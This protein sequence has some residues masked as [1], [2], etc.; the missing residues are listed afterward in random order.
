MDE[1]CLREYFLKLFLFYSRE[2]NCVK[3]M[4]MAPL[5]KILLV[6]W[7][8]VGGGANNG[9]GLSRV[10]V[11]VW[12]A[13]L[14]WFQDKRGLDPSGL[15]TPKLATGVALSLCPILLSHIRWLCSSKMTQSK[16]SSNPLLPFSLCKSSTEQKLKWSPPTPTFRGAVPQATGSSQTINCPG[17]TFWGLGSKALFICTANKLLNLVLWTLK[18]HVWTKKKLLVEKI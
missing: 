11:E 18:V 1:F 14:R 8:G 13:F 15:L 16:Q 2:Q 7:S 12:A 3:F 6:W 4:A 10:R 17:N 5:G 9:E